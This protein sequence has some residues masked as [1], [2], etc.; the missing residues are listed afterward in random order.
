[1]AIFANIIQIVTT[2]IR[3]I[4]KYLKKVK[5]S[6]N[7]ESKYNQYLYF[8]IQQNLL[9]SSEKML[10]SA[11]LKGCV[12]WFIFFWVFFRWGTSVPSFI[13]LG[14][15]WQILGRGE[16]EGFAS[17]PSVSSPEKANQFWIGLICLSSRRHSSEI[18]GTDSF[19]CTWFIISLELF[20]LLV[21]FNFLFF[22]FLWSRN[23]MKYNRD[24]CLDT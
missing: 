20:S 11:G 5:R 15:V 1:M 13:I 8:L 18:A 10:M 3:K 19:L 7:N 6:R 12:T 9:I 22:Q 4:F 24:W 2:F 16:G 23:S 14:Y 21:I 17:H